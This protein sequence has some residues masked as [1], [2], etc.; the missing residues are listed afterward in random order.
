MAHDTTRRAP[1]EH[2]L[3]VSGLYRPGWHAF[4]EDERLPH[5][6]LMGRW[7]WEAGFGVGTRVKVD[8]VAEG[9]LVVRRVE[10]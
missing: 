4:P 10:D 2:K 5:L 7:L 6:P 1:Q 3:T 9:E 8:V